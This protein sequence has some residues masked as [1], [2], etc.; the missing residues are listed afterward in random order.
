MIPYWSPDWSS[1][2]TCYSSLVYRRGSRIDPAVEPLDDAWQR[3][4]A[5][6][7]AVVSPALRPCAAVVA[8]AV[9][10][11]AHSCCTEIK[12][13]FAAYIKVGTEITRTALVFFIPGKWSVT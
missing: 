4:S 12:D 9:A 11:D 13:Q 1:E 8:A 2:A 3:A 5:L 6:V 10:C 7:A